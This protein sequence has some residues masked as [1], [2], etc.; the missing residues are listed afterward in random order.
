MITTTMLAVMVAGSAS[1]PTDRQSA[2]AA[3][4]EAKH[5]SHSVSG[6]G[7]RVS[8]SAE[9]LADGSIR[10][11]LRVRIGSFLF[12]DGDL[13]GRFREAVDAKRYPWVDLDVRAT[14][15]D[16]LLGANQITATGT[17]TMHGV[18]RPINVL[19]R[20]T[21][22]GKQTAE[23]SCDLDLNLTDFGISEMAMLGA[24]L[25]PKIQ[26]HLAVPAPRD[27]PLGTTPVA[28]ATT[29]SQS[30]SPKGN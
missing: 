2:Q 28:D 21:P 3:A 10:A 18:T 15:E 22:N 7:R 23:V 5:E 24:R 30:T 9:I 17:V 29:I 25:D 19:L 26:L 20:V 27:L 12:N 8:G 1:V 16:L 4:F 13:D 11:R 14:S 6:I